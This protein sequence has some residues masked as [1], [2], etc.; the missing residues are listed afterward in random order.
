M[1]DVDDQLRE[2]FSRKADEVPPHRRVPRSLVRRARRRI[3]RN[4]MGVGVAAVLIGV[5]G[6]TG[7]RSLIGLPAPKGVA[8]PPPSPTG[9]TPSPPHPSPS[10][11]AACTSVEVRAS[12]SLEGAAGS[13]VG[14]IVVSNVSERTCTLEG[15]T[16]ISLIDQSLQPITT[17]VTFDLTQ[18]QWEVDGAPKPAGWPVVTLRPG[19]SASVRL[20]WSNWCLDGGAAPG[21]RMSIPG[22]GVIDVDGMESVSP[23]PCN[24]PGQP[25]TIE[26]GPFEPNPGQ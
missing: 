14:D 7:V 4:A 17:G 18:A 8:S 1:S 22:S 9:P 20:R 15:S 26:V 6:F 5:G 11:A 3:A 21:W 2:L 19:D 10:A 12:G 25:S 13:R 23:P 16:N 24:G